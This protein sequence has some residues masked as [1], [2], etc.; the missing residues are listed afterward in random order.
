MQRGRRTET[1]KKKT[2]HRPAFQT[3]NFTFKD[4][5]VQQWT[6]KVEVITFADLRTFTRSISVKS[7]LKYKPM[8]KKCSPF[9][10]TE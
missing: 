9:L 4:R 10:T 3:K 1:K 2:L 8:V 7:Y 5:P 6:S